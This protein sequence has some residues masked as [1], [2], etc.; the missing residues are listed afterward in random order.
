M[1]QQQ[2][3]E[4]ELK[5]GLLS[6]CGELGQ[7]LSQIGRVN[8]I[9]SEQLEN[10]YFD[11]SDKTLFAMHAGLRIRRGEDF[12]E[13]TLKMRGRSLG[14]IH[15]RDEYNVSIDRDLKLPQLNRFPPEIFAAAGVDTDKLQSAL[16]PECVINFKRVSYDFFYADCR[17]E[18]AVDEGRIEAGG[19][20]APIM[21]LE[22]E[23][24]ERPLHH[25]DI[26]VVFDDILLKLGRAGVPLTL[27]PFSKMHRA[28]LL[29]GYAERNSIKLPENPAGSIH[30]CINTNMRAFETLLG[31]FLV[32]H[33]PLY[34][35]YMAYSLSCVRR[36]CL[37]L[38]DKAGEDENVNFSVTFRE[39]AREYKKVSRSLKKLER[40]LRRREKEILFELQDGAEPWMDEVVFKLRRKIS[41]LQAFCLPL[42]LRALIL[43]MSVVKMIN[44]KA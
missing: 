29:L 14:G 21:E 11:T 44:Q 7:I 35:G 27:E 28:A 15:S 18:I 43:K 13:Q 1:A 38:M 20:I 30:A 25:D 16:Q 26:V 32:K 36:S 9:K 42:H 24:K 2:H 33:N 41:K 3:E 39:F 10:T 4:I 17:F 8:S 22:I 6:P 5:L 19:K 31:L 40:Y 23:L 34:L 12:A 37:L